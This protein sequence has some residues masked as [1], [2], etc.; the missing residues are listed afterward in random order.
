[1]A[2]TK[3]I[4]KWVGG[5]TQILS[6][7]LNSFPNEKI[8][9]YHEPFIGGG[10]VL[11]GMLSSPSIHERICGQIYAYDIN[12]P[13]IGMYLNIQSKPAELYTQLHELVIQ[14]LSDEDNRESLYYI[15]RGWYNDLT[16]QEKCSVLGS[17]LFIFLN[18]TC[19]RGIF[20]VGP[21]GFNVPYGHYKN[22]EI[23]NKERLM[24]VHKL[25]QPVKFVCTRFET[26]L[27][28]VQPGDFVY[29]DPPYAPETK[30]SF[31]KYTD[32]GFD[33][34][35][36]QTLFAMIKGL[37][38]AAKYLLSNA[39]VSLVRETFPDQNSMVIQCRRA[40]HSKEPGTTT[41]EVL[42][43]NYSL[44]QDNHASSVSK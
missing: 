24:Q 43:R 30:R 16:P 25:I 33:L 15:A 11:L 6:T 23:I 12:E 4:L 21:N 3:P 40:I 17:A 36:H 42:I 22:P 5:K 41:S 1:M 39:N 7:I 32:K 13:L 10:S 34:D 27:A 26:A 35:Q 28:Q 29:L 14:F 31:V 19:F 20:R 8:N 38:A 9:N 44:P 18:K 37:G 2:T